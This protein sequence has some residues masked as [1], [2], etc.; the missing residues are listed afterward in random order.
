MSESSE[1][2]KTVNSKSSLYEVSNL[3]RIRRKS[4]VNPTNGFTK[5]GGLLSGHVDKLGY[6]IVKI[7]NQA[8]KVHRLVAFAFVPNPCNYEVV[9]HLDGNKLNNKDSNLEWTT[10][11]GNNLHAKETGLLNSPRGEQIGKVLTEELVKQ[12][13]KEYIE[14]DLSMGA[15]ALKFDLHRG[16]VV[17]VVNLTSWEHVPTHIPKEE[18]LA[19]LPAKV[20]LSKSV[21]QHNRLVPSTS[22]Y[23][24]AVTT[25]KLAEEDVMELRKA[26]I[27]TDITLTQLAEKYEVSTTTID[28][29]IQLL[30]W[31]HVP[32]EQ[33]RETYLGLVKAKAHKMRHASKPS[34]KR[35]L[36]KEQAA[37]I[38]NRITAGEKQSKLA[39]EFGVTLAVVHGIWKNKY[40]LT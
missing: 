7:D 18:Y 32:T 34:H 21:G 5:G 35:F 6:H 28:Y 9:N 16:T 3:G 39:I 17:K 10:L 4:G 13:R 24:S 23:G 36:T 26:Y 14:S 29:A 19:K 2:W 33:D 30:S 31:L 27:E 37:E 15:L 38:R 12:L 1:V 22:L 25:S 8:K 11:L 40:Y 20:S